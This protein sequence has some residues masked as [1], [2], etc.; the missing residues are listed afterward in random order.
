MMRKSLSLVASVGLVTLLYG[1]SPVSAQTL[2]AAQSFGVLGGATVTAGS[3]GATING[4]VG[5]APGTSI[6]GTIT[7][8]P[9]FGT[10]NNDAAAIAARAATLT[11]Y[12]TLASMGGATVI[13]PGLNGQSRGPGIYSSGDVTLTSGT[14]LTLTG[15]GQYIFQVNS[16][17]TDVGSSVNLVG[18]N[19]C[20]VFWQVA[21]SAAL[22]GTTFPGNIVTGPAAGAGT[23][24]ATAGASLVGRALASA[25]GDVTMAGGNNTVGGCSAAIV[26]L[27]PPTVTKAFSPASITA[28]GV[29]RFT[30]T[31]SN[32]NAAAI[33]LTAALTDTLPSGVLVAPTPNPTTT[34]GG[35]VTATAGGSTVTLATGSTIPPGFCTIAVNVTAAAAGSFVNT[36]PAGALQTD[37]GNNAAPA[38][39]TLAATP[40]FAPATLPNG[41]VGVLFSQTLTGSGGTAP[42]SFS[43]TAGAL[44][45]GVTLTP[46]GTL[47]L[48]SGTPTAPGTS[49]FTIRVTDAGGF[50]AELPFTMAIAAGVP[51]LPQ[52]FVLL[53]ALGLMAVGYVRLRRRAR[54]E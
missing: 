21:T 51:T 7:V 33:A 35:A 54:A 36:I 15:A 16:I 26:P 9:P 22:N 34:C 31:V 38:T 13:L 19:P 1:T 44:P 52:A 17:T 30:I 46:A 18:V 24:L 20:M 43:V 3:G 5:V 53:L 49:T 48:L 40:V 37:S 2:G 27:L 14:P 29:S 8:V 50:F 12:G 4:D 32:A 47:G 25:A 23:H 39:A 10:H 6:T 42:F 11:L 28:G 41:T 45:A